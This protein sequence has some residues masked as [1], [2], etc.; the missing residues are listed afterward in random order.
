MIH[1]HELFSLYLGNW[2]F[3]AWRPFVSFSRAPAPCFL[4]L[5]HSCPRPREVSPWLWSR[6][7]LYHWPRLRTLCSRLHLCPRQIINYT[8][9]EK[10]ATCGVKNENVKL[11]ITIIV[12][13]AGN[14]R[15]AR[16]SQRGVGAFFEVWFNCKRTWPEFSFG[17]NWIEAN[18]ERFS[19][20]IEWSPKKKSSP[21]FRAFFCQLT[22]TSISHFTIFGDRVIS[23]KKVFTKI[24]SVFCQLTP[25]SI[26]HFTIF[27]GAIFVWGG[28]FPVLGQ[29]PSSKLLKA[30]YFAYCSGQWGG[31]L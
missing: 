11:N 15:V 28:L 2:H 9:S 25:T 1:G 20:K 26:S 18:S 3:L 23:K 8:V 4:G 22:P 14:S 30:C 19:A 29:K 5:E 17:F 31:G 10:S 27:G 13:M 21:K 16:I 12:W 24:Q 7:F 6:I